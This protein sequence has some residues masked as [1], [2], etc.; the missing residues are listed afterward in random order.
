MLCCP[1][2]GG[3][4]AGVHDLIEAPHVVEFVHQHAIKFDI[5]VASL[6]QFFGGHRVIVI[7]SHP[8]TGTFHATAHI[9]P[10]I[11]EK[12][13]KISFKCQHFRDDRFGAFEGEVA[14][15]LDGFLKE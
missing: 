6:E 3:N 8:K 13:I 15:E 1:H 10:V 5:V 12:C 14:L 7:L 9:L 2:I 11:S 4:V